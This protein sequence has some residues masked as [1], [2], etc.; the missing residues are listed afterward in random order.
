MVLAEMRA[1]ADP[2]V[3]YRG[4]PNCPAGGARGVDIKLLL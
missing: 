3:S 1:T 2:P 4:S